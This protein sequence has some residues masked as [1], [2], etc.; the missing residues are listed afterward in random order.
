VGRLR[1]VRR[2]EAQGPRPQ[3][4]GRACG[5]VKRRGVSPWHC[6]SG[7]EGEACEPVKRREVFLP[8]CGIEVTEAPS[9]AVLV[10]HVASGEGFTEERC[11]RRYVR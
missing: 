10:L 3:N 8:L 9:V 2:R 7:G 5:P 1:E 6:G 11:A 4:E